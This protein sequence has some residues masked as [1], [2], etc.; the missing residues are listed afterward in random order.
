MK[1]RKLTS[2][3]D[4]YARREKL[5][6]ESNSKRAELAQVDREIAAEEKREEANREAQ[7]K[8]SLGG[9]VQAFGRARPEDIP[10]LVQLLNPHM[11]RETDRAVHR[12][13]PFDFDAVP[14]EPD[15][16]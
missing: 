8:F 11:T 13:T 7:R 10:A 3:T 9:A 5:R 12:G 4:L 14:T 16:E 1:P 15:H 6:L 2:I